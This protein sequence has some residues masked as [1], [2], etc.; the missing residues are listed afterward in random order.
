MIS[1]RSVLAGLAASAVVTPTMASVPVLDEQKLQ[2][3]TWHK[4]HI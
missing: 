2:Q 4:T 3:V 1:R